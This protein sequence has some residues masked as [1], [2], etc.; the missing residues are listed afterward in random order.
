M[1]EEL[2][3]SD[4]DGPPDDRL[5]FN[6]NNISKYLRTVERP[7]RHFYSLLNHLTTIK[8]TL[9]SAAAAGANC[10]S[11]TSDAA[12]AA[13]TATS[14]TSAATSCTSALRVC[15]ASSAN[16]RRG[17]QNRLRKCKMKKYLSP[18]T[19]PTGNACRIRI[20]GGARARGKP[21]DVSPSLH[22]SRAGIRRSAGRPQRWKNGERFAGNGERFSEN[23]ERFSPFR[24]QT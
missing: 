17:R 5:S 4:D 7:I 11:A 10:P 18:F 21:L 23:G 16:W 12:R 19:L 1:L 22:G 6:W 9:W 14:A 3:P 20:R 8:K 2:P 24:H 13:P 15:A